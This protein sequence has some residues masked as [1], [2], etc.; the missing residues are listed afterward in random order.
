MIGCLRFR[1]RSR[2]ST[3][4]LFLLI[5]A[6]VNA[7]SGWTGLRRGLAGK[8]LNAVFFADSKRGWIA[9]DGG[10]VSRTDDGGTSWQTQTVATSEPVNDIYFRNKDDGYL[11]AGGRIF[12]TNDGGQTWPETH[13]FAS[14]EFGE[15]QL[16]L[17]SVRFTNKKKGWVVGSLSRSGRNGDNIIVDSVIYK[18][19]DGG[20]TWQRQMSP[21]RQELIHLDFADEKHGWIVGSRGT[22]L[23]TGDGGETW[24]QQRSRTDATLYHVEF[25]SEKR[26][27]AVGERGTIIRTSDGGDTWATAPTTVR[28]TLLS[29]QFLNDDDGWS[30]GRGGTILRSGDGGLTWVRQEAGTNQNLYALFLDKK[31]GWAVGA[32]GLVLQYRR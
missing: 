9:G 16:E 28:S 6:G 11:L 8:D 24:V 15:A 1:A 30:V 18:T 7:Q 26:G 22:I 31:N 20:F 29:V 19:T 21:T 27:W 13:S 4:L 32:D 12:T 17:Y 10:F 23:Y 25:R 3:L 14:A 2:F 5:T